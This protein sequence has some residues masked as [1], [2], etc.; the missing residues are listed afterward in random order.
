MIGCLSA[1]RQL[2]NSAQSAEFS[3]VNFLHSTTFTP[4][5]F[6][7]LHGAWHDSH[8][9]ELVVPLLLAHGHNVI[10]PDLP[11]HGSSTLAPARSTLKAYVQ[12][13][14]DLVI[15]NDEPVVLV[16]H[17]MAGIVITEVAARLPQRIRHLVYLCA[18][19]P[20]N[21]DSVFKLI[22]RNRGHE[23]LTAIELALTMS[24]DKRTCSVESD[25]V[26]PLF[27]SDTPP[28]LAATVARRFGIQ[29]SLPL[30]AEAQF[31]S[32]AL[33]AVTASYICCSRDR[34]IPPHHQRRMLAALPALATHELA[35]DH[36]PF[37]S[38]PEPL[39]DLL[40]TLSKPSAL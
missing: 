25:A 28:A 1:A 9:W 18:Y 15:A 33:A 22:A 3:P 23:P 5:T 35:S 2:R 19:L 11:G 12:A 16:G 37:Y 27:Y 8:C 14:S 20:G 30:A 17:S 6:I 10:A 4:S 34:V 26:I 24:D 13:V 31:D 38:C 21:G 40:S 39:A 29:G 7:L 32:A 36:S